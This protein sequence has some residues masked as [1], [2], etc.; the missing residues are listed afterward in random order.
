MKSN[1]RLKLTAA[2]RECVRP[3]S[4]AWALDTRK[5]I[6]HYKEEEEI[7]NKTILSKPIL[8]TIGGILGG[9]F[10]YIYRPSAFIIGQLPFN[11]VISR[12]KTLKG[13]DQMLIPIAEK[14]FNY[15]FSGILIG[16]IT[17][18]ILGVIVAKKN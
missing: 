18:Y 3:R 2:R 4:L 14:S 10:G 8:S 6:M 7:M 11:H 16:V 13:L 12:G 5:T 1:Y 15:L 9:L 17:G